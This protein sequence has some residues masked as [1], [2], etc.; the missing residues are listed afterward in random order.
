M[1]LRVKIHFGHSLKSRLVIKLLS[2]IL[3][4][5]R[6][7]LGHYW[8]PRFLFFVRKI[9]MDGFVPR[10]ILL[11]HLLFKVLDRCGVLRENYLLIFFEQGLFFQI[12]YFLVV[13]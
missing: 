13:E 2:K 4:S 5:L 12:Y 1:D 9:K 7:Y 3:I 10:S 6:T 8:I 11:I